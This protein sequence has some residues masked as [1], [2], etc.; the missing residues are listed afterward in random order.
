M[1]RSRNDRNNRTVLLLCLMLF[2]GL[3]PDVRAEEPVWKEYR[4]TA[5]EGK[6]SYDPKSVAREDSVVDV[7]S[8]FEP[9]A[10]RIREMKHRVR[11]DCARKRMKLLKT[12]TLYRDGS[13]VELPH[14]NKFEAIETGSNPAIL[15]LLVCGET[16]ELPAVPQQPL[17]PLVEKPLQEAQPPVAPQEPVAAPAEK[18][19]Q[20]M[21]QLVAPQPSV[22][23]EPVTE[24]AEKPLPEVQLA[25][26]PMI[27]Q[28]T[29]PL[30]TPPV[31][32][33]VLPQ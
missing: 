18:P 5:A 8:R 22:P 12:I 17:A 11:F 9:V 32:P 10:G 30:E 23:Q 29:A 27:P 6:L 14:K 15:G 21:Q 3:C 19:L 1:K 31:A 16:D 28:Q 2:W 7:W 33:A 20:D 4:T 24:P 26:A 25:P 13:I